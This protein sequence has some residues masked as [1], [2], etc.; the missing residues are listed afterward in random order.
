[1]VKT[2]FHRRTGTMQL[3]LSSWVFLIVLF[4]SAL[5][6]SRLSLARGARMSLFLPL[7]MGFVFGVLSTA[8]G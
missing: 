1:M 5:I 2:L 8:R 6:T 4:A 3:A 7:A